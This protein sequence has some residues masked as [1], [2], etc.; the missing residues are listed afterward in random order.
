MQKE[1]SLPPEDAAIWRFGV[2]SPLLHRNSDAETLKGELQKLAEKTYVMSDGTNKSYSMDTL[3]HWLYLYRSAGLKGLTNKS[4]KDKGSTSLDASFQNQLL[5]LRDANPLW[6]IKRI[7]THMR[8]KDLWN[9]R[10]PSRSAVYRF[11]STHDLGRDPVVKIEA[12][13]SF[14]FEHFGDLWSADFLHGPKVLVN[15]KE[16]KVYLHAIIDDATRYIVC[17]RFHLAEDTRALIND[18]QQAVQRF[19]VPKRFYTDNGS[20]FRSKHLLRVAAKLKM[21]LPHTP[22]STPRGRGKIERFFRSVR[23]GLITGRQRSSFSKI[24]TDLDKWIS[25]YHSRIHS[26]LDQSPLNKK[27]DDNYTLK[28]LEGIQNI[29]YIFRMEEHRTVASDGCILLKGTKYDI[30]GALVKQK[31]KVSY[32]PWDLSVIYVGDEM[33]P[34]KPLNKLKNAHRFNKPKRNKKEK[35]V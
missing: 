33:T 17:A 35:T 2:I 14:E 18:L 4:R 11:A 8:E 5:A 28:Q 13:R 31:M 26:S 30:P 16:K 29:D 21:A 20:A 25:D 22:P 27:L 12:G 19:G 34:V 24:N 7:L 23:D 1:S 9:G 10:K 6:T 15:G 32:T 3:R